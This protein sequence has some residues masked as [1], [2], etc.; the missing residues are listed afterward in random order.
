[1]TTRFH[2]APSAPELARDC[3][4]CGYMCVICSCGFNP[5]P[6]PPPPTVQHPRIPSLKDIEFD[7]Q[8]PRDDRP[9]IENGAG[10][11]TGQTSINPLQ[12]AITGLNADGFAIQGAMCPPANPGA[13]KILSS[14]RGSATKSTPK[15]TRVGLQLKKVS[16][17]KTNEP[18]KVKKLNPSGGRGGGITSSSLGYERRA[19]LKA[20]CKSHYDE[21]H[22]GVVYDYNIADYNFKNIGK[23]SDIKGV[24][25]QTKQSF[26]KPP[27]KPREVE[28]MSLGVSK[29]KMVDL[30]N[31]ITI[32]PEAKIEIIRMF[33]DDSTMPSEKK[34]I[35]LQGPSHQNYH[36]VF[37][38]MWKQCSKRWGNL[39]LKRAF[40]IKDPDGEV[41]SMT[42]P[43]WNHCAINCQAGARDALSKFCK[44]ADGET[45]LQ[46]VGTIVI[47][48]SDEE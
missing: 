31:Y 39:G 29:T 38:D 16:H 1:M 21:R 3:D 9:R 20:T 2:L 37:S 46:H 30:P 4:I 23:L 18:D 40:H 44:P 35:F 14:S 27:T 19:S 7:D 26:F 11:R 36:K 32:K 8:Q 25:V 43:S 15:K 13:Q 33:L 17:K 6:P 12:A 34:Q 10:A 42:L 47:S 41:W 45:L 5:P 22:G 24:K 28:F 48:D